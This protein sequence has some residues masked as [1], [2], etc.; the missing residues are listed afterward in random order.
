MKSGKKWHS[1][2]TIIFAGVALGYVARSI[3]P[4]EPEIAPLSRKFDQPLTLTEES[5]SELP[6][7]P[8]DDGV[9]SYPFEIP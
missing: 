6:I 4:P 7:I 8:V 1:R 3:W 9:L 5:I 2:L